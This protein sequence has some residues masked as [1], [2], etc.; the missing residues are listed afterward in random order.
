MRYELTKVEEDDD[1][2]GDDHGKIDESD[3]N[4]LVDGDATRRRAGSQTYRTA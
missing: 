2:D 1:N 4:V 3:E